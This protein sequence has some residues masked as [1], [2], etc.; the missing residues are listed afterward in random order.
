M[1]LHAWCM[2][3]FIFSFPCAL[4]TANVLQV[5]FYFAF[6]QSYSAFLLFPAVTGLIA[7]L[8]LPNYSLVYAI[9]TVIWC[10]VFLEY[11]KVR[12]VDLSIR[13]QVRGV[14][15]TKTNRPEYK[16]E[17]VVVD[18]YGR[19]IHYTP[20]WKQIARQLVQVPFMA[21]STAALALM[22]SSVFAVEIL[23]SDS[24]DGPNS[25]YLVSHSQA[26]YSDNI[27]PVN[28]SHIY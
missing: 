18:Q 5:A 19:T 16:Y 2:P 26:K 11:W 17:Q 28:F 10:T 23:I 20:K 27:L 7:W 9:L 25:F 3:F 4:S 12:E 8:W 1:Q 21:A 24:Y 15:K 22:I 6:G 14:N 13:W